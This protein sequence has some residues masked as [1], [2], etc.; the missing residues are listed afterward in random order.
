MTLVNLTVLENSPPLI[1]VVNNVGALIFS[2]LG[3]VLGGIILY[4]WHENKKREEKHALKLI[5]DIQKWQNFLPEVLPTEKTKSNNKFD[6]RNDLFIKNIESLYYFE[7]FFYHYPDFKSVW[8]GVC[9][10]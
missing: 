7:D 2:V 1:W 8:G 6:S 4:Y 5:E 3:V 9:I 10:S